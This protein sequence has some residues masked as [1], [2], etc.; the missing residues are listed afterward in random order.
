MYTWYLFRIYAET[1]FGHGQ[2]PVLKQKWAMARPSQPKALK[3]SK[4]FGPKKH[5]YMIFLASPPNNSA[6]AWYMH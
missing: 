5:K 2:R 3:M 6:S 4:I 1:K